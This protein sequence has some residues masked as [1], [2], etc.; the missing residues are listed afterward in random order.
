MWIVTTEI[1]HEGKVCE[2]KC[3]Q[4]QSDLELTV[5]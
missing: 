3:V 4:L 5:F 2:Q 1:G